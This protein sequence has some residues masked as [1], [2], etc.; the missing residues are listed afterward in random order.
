MVLAGLPTYNSRIAESVR[1]MDWGFK[2]WRSQPLFRKGVTVE[3]ADV[4]GA[5]SRQV[6]LVAPRD[7]AV[8]TPVIAMNDLKARVTYTGPIMAPIAQGQHIAD[9]VVTT[10]DGSTQSLPLVAKEAIAK[11]GFFGRLWN[12]F[13]SLF[14]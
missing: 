7:L 14:S 9:L 10:S 6:D 1:F 12:G 8:T 3:K 13:L 4:Q 11:A 2:A 5:W